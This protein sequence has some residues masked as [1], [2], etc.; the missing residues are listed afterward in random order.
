VSGVAAPNAAAAVA[1][2]EAL[3]ASW[4][5]PAT[6]ALDGRL[7]LVQP[8]DLAAAAVLAEASR[9]TALVS[10]ARAYGC[11]HAAIELP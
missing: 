5:I 3:C 6:V 4:G 7:A 9:R 11:T 10:T 8:A 1:A 2:L